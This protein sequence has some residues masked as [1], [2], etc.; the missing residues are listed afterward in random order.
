MTTADIRANA[1]NRA[2]VSSRHGRVVVGVR[3]TDRA[4]DVLAV[5]FA[6]AKRRSS[7]LAVTVIW[8]DSADGG[9]A[10]GDR[11]DPTFHAAAAED[12]AEVERLRAAVA[13]AGRA[14]P[15]VPV[16]TSVRSGHFSDVLV[17]LS[18]SAD[19]VVLGL[20]ERHAAMGRRDLLVA[21]HANC[22]VIVVHESSLE[23]EF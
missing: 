19:L 18:R 22:P 10:S 3:G 1:L 5:A 4:P 8:D 11:L 14:Y 20:G 6:E 23:G 13:D 21:S 15:T 17:E 16:T 12:V 2:A 9:S 7:E